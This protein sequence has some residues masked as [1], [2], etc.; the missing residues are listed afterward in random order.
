[1]VKLTIDGTELQVKD[2][3]TI[4]DAALQAGIHIP[5]LCYLKKLNKIGACRVCMVEVE[6]NSKLVTAC[7]TRASEG[8]IVH[9]N[10]PKVRKTRKINV[11]LIL[12]QHDSNCAICARSGNCTL[13]KL[14]N[15]L[16]ILEMPFEK[17]LPKTKWN[18]DYPLIRDYKKCIKCMRCV[19]VCDKVQSLH[20]WDVAGTGSRTTVDVSLNRKI[21]EAD[22]A[23]CGQCITHC[24]VGA[25][26]ERDDV[27]KVLEALADP[28]KI[29][30][31]QMA[32]AVRA[33]WGEEF[34]LS[35]EFATAGRLVAA[36]RRIGFSYIFDTDFS[37]DL[38]IMEEGSEF[39]EKLKHRD[40][41]TFPMFTS[42]CP[43]WV[44]F[45]KSQYPDM[46]GQLSERYLISEVMEL[47]E[48]A[49]DQVYYR[50]LKM[51]GKS[52]LEQI[53]EVQRERQEYKEYI[54]QW[55]HEVKTPITAIKLICEN[56]RCS[57]TRELM[58]ELENINRFT[59]QA[60]YYARSEHTEKD[61]SVREIS[62]S[63]VVHG[64]IA[65]NKY[66]LRQNNVAVTV[67]DV[68]YSIYSDDKWLRFIL[69]QLISNAV[70]YRADQPVLHFF[71][72]KKTDSIILSVSDNGI[73]IPQGDL[74]R[75][76]EKGFTGQ[77]GRTIHSSTGIGLYLCR[78]LCDK[79]GIGISASSEGKGTTISLSFHI[80]DFVTG[81]QG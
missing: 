47:P 25:L 9:T 20:I 50:L 18:P 36:L 60:L 65:D 13:Q 73:G 10:S 24:P 8:M 19:Q 23:L 7:N 30:V 62:L 17:Q 12:S 28:D 37:A 1:M 59:E 52:M 32:P 80:N 66:L 16:G 63:D 29:T 34:G 45:L 54:E 74:P 11:E 64:A 4:L 56:N 38:T 27:D 14:S 67:E 2:G 43:G 71:A 81:V 39:L 33:A 53:G 76:F 26:R 6:G 41:E 44:R 57:F 35:R 31:V 72:D 78:R 79:L 58:A 75:I 49:E 55:I 77:N 48:Q 42:C 51:A 40:K 68:E 3:T 70:K 22:C 61:Y 69:D 5:T 15:D 46:A 21:E